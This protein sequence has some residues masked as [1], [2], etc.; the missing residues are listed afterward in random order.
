M[1][2][3]LMWLSL[4]LS[5]ASLFFAIAAAIFWARSS[6]VR[7]PDISDTAG[8]AAARFVGGLMQR[9]SRLNANAAGCAAASV[10]AQIVLRMLTA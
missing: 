8:L 3:I 9:Q 6:I 1:D 7:V 4:L 10:V 2:Y 5:W